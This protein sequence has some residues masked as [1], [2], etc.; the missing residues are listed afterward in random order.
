MGALAVAARADGRPRNDVKIRRLWQLVEHVWLAT[1]ARAVLNCSSGA[2]S[3]SGS[4]AM[5]RRCGPPAGSIAI[6]DSLRAVLLGCG[7]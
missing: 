5:T 3:T 7:L 2:A 4:A 1:P 6:F